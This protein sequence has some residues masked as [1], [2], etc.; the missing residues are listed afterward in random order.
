M[1]PR[2][3]LI[4]ALSVDHRIVSDPTVDSHVKILR[5]KLVGTGADPIAWVYGVGHRFEW[6][7]DG[8]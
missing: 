6:G 7:K 2:A 5:R 1:F 8:A 3:Q 4:D